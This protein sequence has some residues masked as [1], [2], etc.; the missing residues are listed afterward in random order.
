MSSRATRSI[1]TSMGIRRRRE[2]EDDD[3]VDDEN[4]GPFSGR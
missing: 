2:V 4:E 1:E 3:D